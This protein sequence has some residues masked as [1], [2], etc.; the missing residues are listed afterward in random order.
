MGGFSE[1]T[2][3]PALYVAKVPEVLSLNDGALVE[4]LA[5]ES[6]PYALA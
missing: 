4:P 2:C 5:S 1:Y 6:G 3:A